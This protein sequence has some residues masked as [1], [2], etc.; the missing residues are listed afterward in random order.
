MVI[1]REQA[2]AISPAY[3]KFAEGDF[4]FWEQ[5][6][7]KFATLK[8]GQEA[9]TYID[10]QYVKV[11]ITSIKHD[12]IRAEDGPMVRVGDGKSTWRVDGDR[13]ACPA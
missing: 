7:K 13:Y 5:V 3:V 1:T 6:F 11:K 8:R 12:D 10:G 9:I 2:L 4:A